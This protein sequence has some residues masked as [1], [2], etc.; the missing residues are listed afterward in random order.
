MLLS[1]TQGTGPQLNR[2]ESV[3]YDAADFC[4]LLGI[5]CELVV[6]FS[7]YAFGNYKEPY[8]IVAGMVFFS[9]KILLTMDLKKDWPV[10]LV[11]ALLGGLCYYRQHSALILRILLMLLAGRDQDARKV[12]QV[13]GAGTALIMVFTALLS[14]AGQHNTLYL[15]QHFRQEEER[16]F[17]FGFY[18]PNGFALFAFRTLL[19]LLY[20]FEKQLKWWGAFLVYFAFL[21]FMLLAGSK[22]GLLAMAVVFVYLMVNRFVQKEELRHAL[23]FWIGL[24]I[25]AGEL[26]SIL[27]VLFY[28]KYL[29]TWEIGGVNLWKYLDYLT[30][31]RLQAARKLFYEVKPAFFGMP[32][33]EGATEIGFFNALYHEGIIFC[34]VYLV[35][36]FG[37]F[38]RLY[39]QKNDLGMLVMT[40]ITI[41][42]M[43]EAFLPYA[44]KN[45]V[46]MLM[47]GNLPLLGTGRRRSVNEREENN[48][49]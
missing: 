12:L 26:V 42:C 25:M 31:G 44:N 43:G 22:T 17:C 15:V 29:R 39:R 32:S 46:F 7:G 48:T 47:I 2:K 3:R 16:R 5:L 24:L 21:P 9:I 27:L 14:A 38:R 37:Y 30:T 1:G 6:S 49:D 13:Y 18:N 34:I 35:L 23:F 4:F 28:M 45:L 19:M 10:F 40:G 33:I 41:Y 8:I 11:C 20:A 36:L